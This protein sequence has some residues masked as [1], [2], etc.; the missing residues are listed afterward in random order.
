MSAIRFDEVTFRYELAPETAALDHLSLEVAAGSL[1][2]VTGRS[3]SGKSTLCRLIAGYAPHQFEGSLQGS[4]EVAGSSVADRTIGELAEHVGVVFEDPF[5]Q[6]TGATRTLFDEV[7]FGLENRGR[8][9]KEI[10]RRVVAALE[11]VG[12]LEL[13]DR[14][15]RELSGG[16]CQRLAIATV[17]A[18]E[19]SI[20]VLD[21]PT[22]Q[23][24]PI[25]SRE[26]AALVADMQ[27]AGLTIVIVAQDLDRWLPHADRLICLDAG[28][29]RA[30]GSPRRVLAELQDEDLFLPPPATELWKRL[31]AERLL[32]RDSDPPLDLEELAAALRGGEQITR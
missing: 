3:G 7:A 21:E 31:R 13:F 2:L 14:H 10:A 12:L 8:P 6:L 5:D 26:V 32:P 15:P 27:R 20:L 1:A 9:P 17:L 29:I 11:K 23:L 18:V 25:G 22:S 30:S 24:D 16:Q 28:Q 19:P 4:V